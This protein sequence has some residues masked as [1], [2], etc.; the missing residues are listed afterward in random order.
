M[1][2]ALRASRNISRRLLFGEATKDVVTTL[3]ADANPNAAHVGGMR[4]LFSHGDENNAV[5]LAT[6]TESPSLEEGTAKSH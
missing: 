1:T 4:Y 2:S 6:L 3:G 5:V